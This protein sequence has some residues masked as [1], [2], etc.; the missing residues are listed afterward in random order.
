MF[1]KRAANELLR[2]ALDGRLCL[3]L[4]PRNYFNEKKYWNEHAENEKLNEIAKS[5]EAIAKENRPYFKFTEEEEE[6]ESDDEFDDRPNFESNEEKETMAESDSE[7]KGEHDHDDDEDVCFSARKNPY[8]MLN[9][10]EN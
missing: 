7:K 3:S 5:V 10:E 6:E 8:A 9:A 4:K 2:M 1:L